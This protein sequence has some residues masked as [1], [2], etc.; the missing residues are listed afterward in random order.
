MPEIAL[1]RLVAHPGNANRMKSAMMTTLIA[2]IRDSGQYPPL[3]VR[4]HPSLADHYQIL[5]GH[6][7]ADALQALGRTEAQCEVWHVD[8]AR[9]SLLLLTLNRLQGQDDPLRRAALLSKLLEGMD[10]KEL[11]R[12]LPD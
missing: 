11:A 7:R 12:R 10:V 2:H 5:D 1:K 4:P 3:I 9:A 8:D 6:H